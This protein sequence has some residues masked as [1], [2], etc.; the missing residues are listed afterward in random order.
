MV[1]QLCHTG[2]TIP[3]ASLSTISSMSEELYFPDIDDCLS[4][5][6]D[7]GGTCVDGVNY[8]LCECLTGFNGTN[9]TQGK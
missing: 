2:Y 9:C 5:P 4:S 7:N 8:Y 3:S 6:C 1:V